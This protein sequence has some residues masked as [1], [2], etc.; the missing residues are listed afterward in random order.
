MGGNP[1]SPRR[2]LNSRAGES[3]LIGWPLRVRKI[4][5]AVEGLE[6]GVDRSLIYRCRSRRATQLS[7]FTTRRLRAR[8]VGAN[9]HPLPFSSVRFTVTVSFSRQKSDQ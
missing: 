1:A 5:R 4:G 6:S 2:R 8:L 3:L 9:V 7:S